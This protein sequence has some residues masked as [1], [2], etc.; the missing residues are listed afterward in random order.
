MSFQILESL[1]KLIG[2]FIKKK[3]MNI[4][5][6]SHH[7]GKINWAAVASQ[8]TPFKIDGVIIKTST[9]V[10]GSDPRAA[11]NAAEAK[12][13]GLK[14]G[15]YHYCSMNSEDELK[16]STEEA[17]W[18]TKVLKSLPKPDLPVVLDIEDP[19]IL[20][21][22]DDGEVYAWIKNFFAVMKANGYNDYVLYSFTPFLNDHLPL[23]H[24]LGS[25]RL[26]IARWGGNAPI[27]PKGWKDYWLWQYT[28]TG[29]V[30]G[31]IGNVDLNKK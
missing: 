4:I 12:R 27:L 20:T 19:E 22:L 10:G 8:V 24:D 2:S 1:G 31:I 14:V 11:F 13:V 23:N 21:S 17:A 30:K 18:F 29:S 7:N 26:W 28:E 25:I 6:I 5:D 3:T 9:G 16:D 15:Y